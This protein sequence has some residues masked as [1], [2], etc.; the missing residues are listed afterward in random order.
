MGFWEAVAIFGPSVINWFGNRD[1]KKAQSEAND[2]NLQLAMQQIGMQKDH[3]ALDL[4]FKANLQQAT[5]NR[6]KRSLPRFLQR[7]FTP[8]NPYANTQRIAP[9]LNQL[10]ANSPL[11]SALQQRRQGASGGL[12][13][14]V[15]K[16]QAMQNPILNRGK[17]GNLFQAMSN[18]VPIPEQQRQ[19]VI[20]LIKP[21]PSEEGKAKNYYTEVDQQNTQGQV[22]SGVNKSS[23]GGWGD[24]SKVPTHNKA[25]L[26]NVM[27]NTQ[28][29]SPTDYLTALGPNATD[30]EIEAYMTWRGQ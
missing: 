4:P 3:H 25:M 26:E 9:S 22:P 2:A 5:Q 21:N 1:N 24:N 27:Q 6:M 13:P 10:R 8:T 23:Q 14:K 16:P 18:P 17:Y 30:E 29:Q 28:G 15:Q 19:D 12:L 7:S 20:N 11:A